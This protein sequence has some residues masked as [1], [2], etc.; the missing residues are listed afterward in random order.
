MKTILSYFF[1]IG[2]V[3]LATYLLVFQFDLAEEGA[4]IWVFPSNWWTITTFLCLFGFGGFYL[5]DLIIAQKKW[6]EDKRQKKLASELEKQNVYERNIEVSNTLIEVR[7][8][9]SGLVDK[10]A[11]LKKLDNELFSIFEKTEQQ[12]ID[13]VATLKDLKSRHKNIGKLIT[14][15]KDGDQNNKKL[16]DLRL[17]FDS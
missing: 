7:T 4:T 3:I 9:A 15:R 11:D 8:T 16:K 2:G 13:E 5:P 12:I 6:A 14:S 17:Y 10:V 1:M